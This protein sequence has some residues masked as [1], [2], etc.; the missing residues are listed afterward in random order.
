MPRMPAYSA[1]LHSAAGTGTP[2]GRNA[3]HSSAAVVHSNVVA[4][5]GTANAAGNEIATATAAIA[6]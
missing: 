3:G 2:S 6:A 1:A 5:F 4:A